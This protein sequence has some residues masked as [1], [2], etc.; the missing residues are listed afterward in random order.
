MPIQVAGAEQGVDFDF[1]KGRITRLEPGARILVVEDL[2]A[3]QFRY[4]SE[5]PVTGQWSGQLSNGGELLTVEAAGVTVQQFA[6]ADEWYAST[7]G[8]GMSLELIDVYDANPA[9]W[10]VKESWSPSYVPGGT[11]GHPRVLTGD[12]NHDGRFDSQDMV[13]VFQAGKYED[14]I[15]GN[16]TFEDGDWNYDGDFASDDMILAFQSG[17]YEAEAGLAARDLAAAVDAIFLLSSRGHVSA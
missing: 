3:F 5:L 17:L 1:S 8:G 11:P 15:F 7:D 2:A 14:D 9:S 12:S 6:Y 16:A 10:G 13:L 4:G